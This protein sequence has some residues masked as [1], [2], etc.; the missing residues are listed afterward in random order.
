MEPPGGEPPSRCFQC[1]D[2]PRR[3]FPLHPCSSCNRLVCPICDLGHPE[4]RCSTCIYVGPR[5]G[6]V[7]LPPTSSHI[8]R[9]LTKALHGMKI[10]TIK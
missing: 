1:G 3:L 8:N 5:E 2:G 7:A 6:L 9:K 4:V 10:E